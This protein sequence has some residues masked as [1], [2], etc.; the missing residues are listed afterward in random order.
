MA[1]LAAQ[2][3]DLTGLVSSLDEV[4]WRTPS[5]CDGWSISDVVLHLA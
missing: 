1:A 4:G 2:Q 5:R 3:D